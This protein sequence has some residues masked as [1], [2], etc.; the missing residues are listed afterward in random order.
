MKIGFGPQQFFDDQG[1][2]LSGGRLS[3]YEQG[4]DNLLP[5]W[6]WSGEFV[7]SD[8]PVI[9]D[10]AGRISDT[11]WFEASVIDVKLEK[12][13]D[14]GTYAQVDTYSYG[15]DMPSG[16]NDTVAAGMS[17]LKNASPSLGTVTVVGYHNSFDA[18]SRTY[19]WDPLSTDTPDDGCVVLSDVEP[20]GRWLLV[21]P[22]EKLPASVYGVTPG[23]L[24]NM[25]NLMNRPRYYGNSFVISAPGTTSFPS[26]TFGTGSSNSF[27]T[28]YDLQ[29]DMG[30]RFNQWVIT[31]PRFSVSGMATAGIGKLCI[32]QPEGAASAI[33]LS[34]IS[35]RSAFMSTN[36]NMYIIDRDNTSGTFTGTLH[37]KLVVAYIDIPSWLT[38][39]D[40]IILRPATGFVKGKTVQA[41]GVLKVGN[42]FRIV[43]HEDGMYRYYTV[44]SQGDD[45]Y[46]TMRLGE[47]QNVLCYNGLTVHEGFD[48]PAHTVNGTYYPQQWWGYFDDGE[49]GPVVQIKAKGDIECTNLKGNLTSTTSNIGTLNVTSEAKI[50]KLMGRNYDF[51]PL[52]SGLVRDYSVVDLNW[53]SYGSHILPTTVPADALIKIHMTWAWSDSSS[54]PISDYIHLSGASGRSFGDVIALENCGP[55]SATFTF[56]DMYRDRE[57][58]TITQKSGPIYVIDMSLNLIDIIPAFERHTFMYNGSGWERVSV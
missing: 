13:N 50:S 4:T 37:N 29:L 55:Q 28:T 54:V 34:E 30:T 57:A 10:N 41:S 22:D 19:V 58:K 12:L 43:P 2:P 9:L 36:A 44:Y 1:R 32:D 5:T 27:S 15:M 38:F 17:G 40:S 33:K 3:L 49:D 21:W 42:L 52:F 46:P 51:I 47:D 39:E 35:D 56:E 6:T 20:T 53:T 18:P 31:A 48:I 11:V 7:S 16:S 45:N 23:H 14:D 24:D 26:G 8:N 25:A